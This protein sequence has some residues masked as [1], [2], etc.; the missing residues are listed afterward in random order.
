MELMYERSIL[1][2]RQII[3]TKDEELWSY[4]R[5]GKVSSGFK[6]AAAE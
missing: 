4:N 2:K 5:Y 6:M 3:E 1:E